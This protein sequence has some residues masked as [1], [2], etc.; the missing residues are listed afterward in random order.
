M[1]IAII[2]NRDEYSTKHRVELFLCGAIVFVSGTVEHSD[3][4]V[5]KI[6]KELP[7]KVLLLFNASQIQRRDFYVNEY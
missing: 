6:P 5:T 4:V 2:H 1:F 7:G 3:E